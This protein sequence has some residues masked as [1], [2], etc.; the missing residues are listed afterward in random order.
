MRKY[1]PFV[2]AALVIL[3]GSTFIAGA[4]T[5]PEKVKIDDCVTKK[6]AVEFPHGAHVKAIAECKTCHHTQPALT[7]TSTE[8]VET[9]GSCHVAPEKAE[10]PKCSEMSATKN[11]FHISCVKCH[12]EEL[13]KKADTKAP[14]KCDQCHPKA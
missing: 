8:K 11:P 12:K 4:A 14:T 1:M 6:S 7:A 3:A 2:L 13:A 9:C 5:P 10:T